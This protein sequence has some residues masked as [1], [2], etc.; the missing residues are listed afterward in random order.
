MITVRPSGERGIATLDWLDS[1]HT[2]SF[3]HYYDPKHMGFGSLRVINEDK[4]RPA[5]G[6]GTHSHK[7]MEIITYVLE[8]ELEHKDSLGNGS[9]MR[10][11]DVQR[12]SAGTGIQHSEFNPSTTNPVHF[13]QIW[14][15]PSQQG[16]SPSYEQTTFTEAEKCDRLRLIGSPDGREGSVTIHQDV[17]LYAALLQPD[18]DVTHTLAPTRQAWLQVVRGSV[19]LNDQPLN[20]GDGVAITSS[21]RAI[22]HPESAQVNTLNFHNNGATAAE[23]LL[24]DME[25]SP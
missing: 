6:F 7:D 3:S 9:V 20:A 21:S 12:M 15:L 24:F 10:Y 14:I 25:L 13:L 5:Q 22:T 18:V 19:M 17:N 1:R 2:F 11:G 16:I 8:G 23:V 4:V